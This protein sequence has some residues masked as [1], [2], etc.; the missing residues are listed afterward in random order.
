[1]E[2]ECKRWGIWNH[3]KN[4]W[5]QIFEMGRGDF[6]LIADSEQSIFRVTRVVR[7]MGLHFR[8]EIMEIT[9]DEAFSHAREQR[10]SGVILYSDAGWQ[11]F[12]L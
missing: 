7:V 8:H 9:L 4:R 3:D 5:A 1:M 11:E 10:L 12:P 6:V 2:E